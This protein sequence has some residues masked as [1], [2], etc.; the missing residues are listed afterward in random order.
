MMSSVQPQKDAVVNCRQQA[1]E[2]VRQARTYMQAARLDE[3][4]SLCCRAYRMDRSCSNALVVLGSVQAY[5]G[6]LRR[7]VSTLR[8]A[9]TTDPSNTKA[10]SNLLMCMNYSEVFHQ[11][12][13]LAQSRSWAHRFEG[14]ETS[15]VVS[16]RSRI[17]VAYLSPDFRRH[18]VSYFFKPLIEHHDRNR[19]EVYCVSDVARPDQVTE[20]LK[21]L[22]DG[23]CDISTRDNDD[24]EH[25]IRE[26]APDILVDLAGHTGQVIRLPLFARR[27]APVQ[28]SW[29]GYPNTTGL[30]QMD[31]RITD[32]VADPDVP[33]FNAHYTERLLRLSRCFLCYQ[34]PDESPDVAPP[35]V[36]KNDYITFGCFNMLPKLQEGMITLWAEIL[37]RIQ[38]SRLVLKNHYFR[39]RKTAQRLL[40]MFEKAGILPE[41]LDLLPSVAKVE[42]HLACYGLVDIALDTYPYN[43]TTT[44]C[45]ALWM[46][47]PVITLTGERH[48]SRVGGSILRSLGMDLFVAKQ[49]D[50]YRQIAEKLAGNPEGLYELRKGLRERV[51]K[52]PLCDARTFTA[53]I[54][55]HF[56][57]AYK[58]VEGSVRR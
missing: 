4:L 38:G 11:S 52:S 28:V 37:K 15:V 25:V 21:V 19:F 47:V 27:L 24:V 39:D 5:Q 41:R 49:R 10:H 42:D 31:Y 34:P 17:R 9:I 58:D 50:E 29:L 44:T 14:I 2:L 22:A 6:R 45:E 23:W 56:S 20:A 30:P 43:G 8:R 55:E 3:A 1:E 51:A 33:E 16:Q 54:E 13:I 57:A 46:G 32:F 35:P 18:S 40:E 12:D 36:L 48:A 26:I 7:A 53:Q